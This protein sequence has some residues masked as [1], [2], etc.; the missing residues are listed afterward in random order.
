[1]RYMVIFLAHIGVTTITKHQTLRKH[2]TKFTGMLQQPSTAKVQELTSGI[3]R[4][5]K[6]SICFL[7]ESLPL[8]P[9]LAQFAKCLR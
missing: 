9:A 2:R 8:A 1:M 4:A 6:F 5:D 3:F 7:S